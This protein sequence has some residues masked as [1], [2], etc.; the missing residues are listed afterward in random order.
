MKGEV[1]YADPYLKL[2]FITGVSKFAKVSIFSGLNNL[3]DITLDHRFAA[4]TGITGD[5]LTA[6]FGEYLSELATRR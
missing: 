6:Y 1:W 2:V 4:I 5:E 3:H